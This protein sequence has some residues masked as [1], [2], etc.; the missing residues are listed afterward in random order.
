[1]EGYKITTLDAMGYSYGDKYFLDYKKAESEFYERLGAV[2]QDREE[3]AQPEDIDGQSPWK[4]QNEVDKE[5]II[6]RAY[7]LLWEETCGFDGCESY[8]TSEEIVFEKIE[9]N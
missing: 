8:I 1:M 7:C 3:L 2:I 5:Q 6:K 4:I 9:I